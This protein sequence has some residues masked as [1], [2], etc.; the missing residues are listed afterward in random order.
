M[1]RIG[2]CDLDLNE[3]FGWLRS[4]LTLLAIFLSFFVILFSD[5]IFLPLGAYATQRFSLASF[6]ALLIIVPA[7]VFLFKP[8]QFKM[9]N[10]RIFVPTLLLVSGFLFSALNSLGQHYVWVEPGMYAFFFLSVF[11]FGVFLACCRWQ[12]SYA[13]L[14]VVVSTIACCLYG[15]N[16]AVIYSFAVSDG[17]RGLSNFIPWGFANVRYWGH[18]AT[19]CMPLLPLAICVSPLKN[20][21]AW[22]AFVL[23]G[24]G[25][26]WWI[27]F[28]TASR[29]SI[30]G[31]FFGMTLTGVLFGKKSLP[32]LKASLLCFLS[33]VI[34][35]CV[36][37]VLVPMFFSDDVQA[38]TIKAGD[39]G[40][41]DLYVEAWNMSL[42]NFP[43]GMGVQSW[44][45][46]DPITTEYQNSPKFAHPHNMYLMWAAEYG[47]FL[48][49]VMIPVVL[50]AILSFW[51]RRSQL[52]ESGG[53]ERLLLLIGFTASVSAALFHAG[54]S[55]V[56]MAPA[57]MLVGLWVLSGFWGLVGS[58]STEFSSHER[59]LPPLKAR[60]IALGVVG[61]LI[62][63]WVLWVSEV[64]LYYKDMRVDESQYDLMSEGVQPRFWLHGDFPR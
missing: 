47:W 44:I 1:L 17:L 25:I 56:F 38:R 50:Q 16:S 6:M 60:V 54:V 55:A 12:N 39:S 4:A 46:H 34:F 14:L 13:M 3:E 20:N 61:F 8:P 18:I 42:K 30:L 58:E 57:S 48:I 11:M 15:L 22:W 64:W 27:L 59:L 36:L 10:L 5:Y 52:L 40:R 28:F 43:F 37:S 45:T 41:I 19:W 49:A 51:R 63:L 35:W 62:G 33:G 26:W 9:F 32:W 31:V 29:G 2:S 24:A 7:V 23:V 53:S 21:R